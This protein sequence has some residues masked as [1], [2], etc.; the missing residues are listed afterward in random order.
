M[1][2]HDGNSVGLRERSQ[3][4]RKIRVL[5]VDD[6]KVIRD[7]L[8]GLLGFEPDI[9]VVGVA[10]DGIE[11]VALAQ[12]LEPD[13]VTMDVT[14]PGMSGLEATRIITQKVPTARIIG[15]SMHADDSVAE[16]MRQAGAVAYLT[17]GGAEEDL[18]A[19]I[20]GRRR[21]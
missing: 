3:A 14:M 6:H 21:V 20:R 11:A 18:L 4:G 10:T 15:L 17:K 7:G 2:E 19:A 8:A 16:A 1:V 5:L 13:V 12:A 9:E